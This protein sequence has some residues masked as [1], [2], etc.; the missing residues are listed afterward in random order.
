MLKSINSEHSELSRMIHERGTENWLYQGWKIKYVSLQRRG[1]DTMSISNGVKADSSSPDLENEYNL[2]VLHAEAREQVYKT[3]FEESERVVKLLQPI[4]DIQ[5]GPSTLETLDLFPGERGGAVLIFLHGG[6][7]RTLDKKLFNFIAKHLVDCGITFVNVNYGLAPEISI[8]EIVA[9]I[10]KAV[11]WIVN[12]IDKYG[13]DP[14]QI[15]ISG[16]SAGGHLATMMCLTDWVDEFKVKKPIKG[17]I[18]ISGLFDLEPLLRISVN[19]ELKLTT[20]SAKRNSPID[21]IHKHDIPML[22]AVGEHETQ[23]FKQQ[24]IRFLDEFRKKGNDA[25]LEIMNNCNHFSV[26]EFFANEENSFFKKVVNQVNSQFV[27]D[28]RG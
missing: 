17:N 2:R 23:A 15:S 6:Y 13:A 1:I 5:Y 28:K 18:V 12:N 16:H 19:K 7:W 20:T 8:D 25:E 10:R 3:F 22:F 21:M 11:M 4:A 14:N 26:L 27:N 24:T 9:Q